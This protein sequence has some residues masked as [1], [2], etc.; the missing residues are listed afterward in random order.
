M[1]IASSI[2][3]MLASSTLVEA[4]QITPQLHPVSSRLALAHRSAP[5]LAIVEDT[6]KDAW[7]DR[8][9]LLRPS[10]CDECKIDEEC[11]VEPHELGTT[12]ETERVPGTLRTVI[13]SSLFCVLVAIPVLLANPAVLPKLVEVCTPLRLC[14]HARFLLTQLPFFSIRTGGRNISLYSRTGSMSTIYLEP[15]DTLSHEGR[16]LSQ[17]APVAARMIR[18]IPSGGM[19]DGRHD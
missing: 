5:L 8:F 6:P 10:G 16:R 18:M 4:L 9:V 17:A 7:F 19:K 14:G 11:A 12:C 2:M 15:V 13:F 1:R 3:Y